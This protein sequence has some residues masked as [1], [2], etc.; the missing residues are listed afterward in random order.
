MPTVYVTRRLPD[1]VMKRLQS[2]VHVSF[3]PNDAEPVPRARLLADVAGA[4][5]II[6]MLT[7]RV[8]AEVMDAAGP[9]LRVIA[10]LAVGYDNID[11]A[12]AERRGVVVTNTPDVLTETTADLTFALMMAAARQLPSA[13][14]SLRAGQWRAWSLLSY[15]GVDVYGKCL[16]IVGMGRIGEALARRAAGFGMHI[17]YFNRH[18]RPQAEQAS[19]AA[20]CPFDELLATA[21]FVVALAPLTAETRGMFDRRA[22]G[23]MKR[24]AVFVNTAR[25]PIVDEEA[26]VE[27]L[28]RRQIFAAGLDV[29]AEEPLPPEHPLLELDNVVLLPHIGSASV[30]TRLAMA[31]LAVD[32]IL[33]VLGGHA[34]PTPVVTPTN[35]LPRA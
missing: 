24:T 21:D 1:E 6:S 2:S 29:Y 19:G 5:G 17:L 22:F 34:P 20:F 18:R 35:R 13:E 4:D 32:N 25:G 11:V 15:T 31:H 10:N 7:D 26:L 23:L 30:E 14:R 8:D 16:G 12:E 3:Y 9:Q 28:R 27:A 33:A